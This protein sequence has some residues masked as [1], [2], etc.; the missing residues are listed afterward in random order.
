MVAYQAENDLV[1]LIAP[2]YFR[3][4]D[5]GRTP[6]QNVLSARVQHRDHRQRVARC[7]RTPEFTTPNP[8]PRCALRRLN[9]T[10]TVFPGT[11]LRLHNTVQPEPPISLALPGPRLSR[12]ASEEPPPDTLGLG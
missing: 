4:E 5:E 8:C 6:I 1:R 10:K 2:H 7:N 12:T 9:E 11:R 3:A